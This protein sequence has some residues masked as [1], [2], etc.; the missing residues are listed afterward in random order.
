ML[1]HRA[2]LAFALLAAAGIARAQSAP[3]LW[4]FVDPNSQAVIGIDWARVRQSPAGEMIRDQWVPRGTL[5]GFPGLELLNSVERFLISSPLPD[6]GAD[7]PDAPVLIAI[8]GRFDAAEVHGLF[9]RSRANVQAYNSFQ[10]YRPRDGQHRNMAYVSFDAQTILYGDAPSVFAAL[11]RNRFPQ[12]QT[13]AA[14]GSMAAR[15]AALDAKYQIWA[16]VDANELLANDSFAALFGASQWAGSAQG[17]EA[18]L[19]LG[20]GLDADFTVRFSS[21]DMAKRVNAELLRAVDLA[22]KDRRAGSETQDIVKGLRSSVE[23]NATRINLH[24][25]PQELK[26]LGEAFAAGV[27]RGSDSLASAAKPGTNPVAA[28]PA[29]PSKPAVIRIEGLD[30]GPREIPYEDTDR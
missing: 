18:G 20:S 13:E 27:Q 7:G 28:P 11:D 26:G 17:I 30:G 8:Q 9:A 5:A 14:P 15:A 25:N 2:H 12:P 19:N 4:R 22:A 6:S 21:E 24:L 29:K 16:I 1:R 3:A 23:G 10:V